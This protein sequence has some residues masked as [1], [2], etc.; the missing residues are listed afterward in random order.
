M[1]ESSRL[2]LH[3]GDDKGK[4]G[5]LYIPWGNETLFLHPFA[6]DMQMAIEKVYSEGSRGVAVVPVRRKVPWFWALGEKA[7]DWWHLPRDESIWV[8]RWGVQHTQ[9]HNIHTR[10]VLFDA[11]QRHQERM[12]ATDRTLPQ[13]QQ[14]RNPKIIVG[15]PKHR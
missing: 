8:D 14:K 11:L 7:V 2:Q 13:V 3:K 12:N 10:V 6:N 1:D 15:R 5:G 9:K 4:K